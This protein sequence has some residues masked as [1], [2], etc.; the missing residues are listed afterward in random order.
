M[1]EETF[2][3]FV[4]REINGILGAVQDI[5]LKSETKK[6]DYGDPRS[7]PEQDESTSIESI[8]P[9]S[10]VLQ[11]PMDQCMRHYF[12]KLKSVS[13][14]LHHSSFLSSNSTQNV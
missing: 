9:S 4:Y 10:R 8:I 1:F 12:E 5:E 3:P 14:A 2:L 13:Y 11:D 7:E 6:T